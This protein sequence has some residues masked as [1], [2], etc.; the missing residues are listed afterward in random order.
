MVGRHRE[1]RG[2]CKRDSPDPTRR[3]RQI[4]RRAIVGGGG[5]RVRALRSHDGDNDNE[6]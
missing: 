6:K 4:N 5:K 2:C 1:K 3:N